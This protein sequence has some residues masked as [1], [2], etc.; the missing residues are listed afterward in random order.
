MADRSSRAEVRNPVLRLG[1]LQAILR[2]P[3]EVRELLR[4]LFL[5]LAT[6]AGARAQAC[7]FGHKAPMATYWKGVSVYAK[8]IARAIGRV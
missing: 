6:D 4:L 8:H 3:P 5:E 1:S 2:L 7:W